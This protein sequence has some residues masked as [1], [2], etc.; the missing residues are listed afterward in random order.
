MPAERL[1]ASGPDGRLI[2]R[3]P[4]GGPLLAADSWLVQDGRVRAIDRHRRRFFAGC[5]EVG[6]VSPGQLQTFWDDALARL[7]RDGRWFPRVELCADRWSPLRLRI[8]PAPAP[9]A[10][11]RLWIADRPDPRTAPRRKGP[12]LPLLAEVRDVA[13]TQGA[14]EA[15]LTARSGAVLEAAY[16]SVLW[17]DGD[18]LC[19]PFPRLPTLAGVTAALIR[20][21]AEYLGVR[22]AFQYR[23]PVH[24]DG[25]EVWLANALHG[26][27]PVV[28]WPGSS[29]RPGA[30][31]HASTWQRWLAGLGQPLPPVP[32]DLP[33]AGSAV[34]MPAEF[35]MSALER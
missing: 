30:A 4:E 10:G 34:E 7:P 6:T 22:V 31:V 19:L 33:A 11:V 5:A 26:I 17:W 14:Q 3:A 2:E 32:G 23:S 15:L 35:T 21:R 9:T 29:L 25:R 13:V 16:A 28:D 1:F 24:L 20:E 18:V 27:R 8:R 12:D